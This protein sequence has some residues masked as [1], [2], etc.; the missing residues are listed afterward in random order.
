MYSSLTKPTTFL[1]VILCP[2]RFKCKEACK[3]CDTDC[4]MLECVEARKNL[5]VTRPAKI[6]CD[7]AWKIKCNQVC[8]KKN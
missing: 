7:Q 2:M 8:N 4:K 3:K 6:Q 1:D 5:N